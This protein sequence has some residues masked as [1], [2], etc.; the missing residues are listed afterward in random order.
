MSHLIFILRWL[1]SLRYYNKPPK[2]TYSFPVFILNPS[3]MCS[4]YEVSALY[5]CDVSRFIGTQSGDRGPARSSARASAVLLSIY[6]KLAGKDID[7]TN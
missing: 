2:V 5:A 4:L 3:E 7:R 6:E 1:T